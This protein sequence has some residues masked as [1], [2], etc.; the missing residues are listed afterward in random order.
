MSSYPVYECGEFSRYKNE[1]GTTS[2]YR[3]GKFIGAFENTSAFNGLF[4]KLTKE[5]TDTQEEL[6]K[7]HERDVERATKSMLKSKASYE[8]K[9]DTVAKLKKIKF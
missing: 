6:K 2:C 1:D 7:L 4:Y 9:K 5:I 3:D 8:K